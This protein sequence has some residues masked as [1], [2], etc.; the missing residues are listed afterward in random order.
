MYDD[1]G[2]L[3]TLDKP[4]ASVLGQMAR[5][6]QDSNTD[7]IIIGENGEIINRSEELR[8]QRSLSQI[9][10]KNSQRKLFIVTDTL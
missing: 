7:D 2:N 10:R 4:N 5:K 1:D 6:I 3:V 9:S 8:K